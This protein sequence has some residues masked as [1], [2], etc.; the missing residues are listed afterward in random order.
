MLAICA[1]H[2][3]M[4]GPFLPKMD[5][6]IDHTKPVRVFRNWKHD[7]YSIMQHG[8]VRASARHVRLVDVE[9]RV[10]EAGRRKMLET[11]RRNV[12]AYAIG[13]LVDYV[14]PSDPREF[15]GIG[16]RIVSYD[17]YHYSSFVDAETLA[18]VV[19]ARVADFTEH[20]VRYDA[21]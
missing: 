13:H 12:H 7:C 17:P 2:H 9:F 6:V 15:D 14:H 3:I 5:D 1:A 19:T 4:R 8:R 11:A 16:A 18:P 10:R 21:A 20:G